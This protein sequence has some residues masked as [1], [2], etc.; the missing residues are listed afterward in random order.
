[1]KHESEE[2]AL[3]DSSFILPP[4]SFPQFLAASI[5]SALHRLSA[6]SGKA[7]PL[8][9]MKCRP[10][11]LSERVHQRPETALVFE[12]PIDSLLNPRI[13]SRHAGFAEGDEGRPR[14]V[15]VAR[16]VMEFGLPTE[17]VGP[18]AAAPR[19]GSGKCADRKAA[20]RLLMLPDHLDQR[21]LLRFVEQPRHAGRGPE[22]KHASVV[23]RRLRG[24]Q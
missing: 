11:V 19:F 3:S 8:Y 5:G 23:V 15:A 17:L 1:M 12:E 14:H 24:P 9:V 2:K 13:G 18:D 10:S 6:K 20:V 7:V 16:R 4:S 21:M 22:Q